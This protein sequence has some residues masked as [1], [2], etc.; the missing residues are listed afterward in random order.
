MWDIDAAQGTLPARPNVEP[1][2]SV[3]T[4]TLAAHAVDMAR[5][6]VLLYEQGQQV[7]AVPVIRSLLESAATA[8]WVLATP[9]AWEGLVARGARQ[10]DAGLKEFRR[11][12]PENERADHAEQLVAELRA[13]V[14][15]AT[16]KNFEQRILELQGMSMVYLQYRALSEHTHAGLGVFELYQEPDAEPHEPRADVPVPVAHFQN[17]QHNLTSAMNSLLHALIAWDAVTIN[18]IRSA[19]LL[20]IAKHFGVRATPARRKD[21]GVPTVG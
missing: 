21:D 2:V 1:V 13:S 18:S 5:G 15:E 20:K 7:A 14:S 4:R 11:Y 17:G 16:F 8:H 3:C 6:V 12:E 10:V 9:G 19:Q